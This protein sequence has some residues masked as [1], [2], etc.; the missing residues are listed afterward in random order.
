MTDDQHSTDAEDEAALRTEIDAE[1]ARERAERRRA[2]AR[3]QG[4]VLLIGGVLSWIAAVALMNDKLFLLE[5]PNASLGCDVNP[6]VSCGTVMTTWQAATFGVPNMVLGIAGYALMAAIGSL[7]LSRAALP[8]WFRWATLGGMAFAFLFLHFL[9]ISAIFVIGALCPW[10]M[11]VWAATGPMFFV[12]LAN[13]VEDRLLRPGAVRAGILRHWVV[14]AAIW[15]LLVIV[16]IAI[17]F[18]MRFLTWFGLA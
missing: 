1:L 9:A 17:E 12:T 14:L 10:C 4:A 6:F 16:A 11:V 18:G 7:L 8:P 13:L 2:P 15:Y 3:L 5:N